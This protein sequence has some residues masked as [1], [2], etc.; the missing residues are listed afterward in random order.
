M[1]LL[2]RG[3]LDLAREEPAVTLI[4][5]LSN[6]AACRSAAAPVQVPPKRWRSFS[7]WVRSH[8]FSSSLPPCRFSCS[9]VLNINSQA[10]PTARARR[11][12]DLVDDRTGQEFLLVPLFSC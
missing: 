6:A 7:S 4:N 12:E 2:D 1:L 10:M 8:Q 11:E 9:V 3:P 5:R